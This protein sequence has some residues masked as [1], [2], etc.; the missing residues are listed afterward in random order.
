MSQAYIL[1]DYAGDTLAP[2]TIELL[3]AARVLGSVT[4]VVVG[5]PGSHLRFVEDLKA[6]GADT[7]IGAEVADYSRRTII[8]EVDAL[9]MLAAGNPGP[10][11][12][13]AGIEGNEIAGRLAARLASGVLCDVVAINSDRSATMSIFG[14]SIEVNAVVGGT[15]P[16]YTLRQGA[17]DSRQEI[18]AGAG[19]V[20]SFALPSHGAK[21]CTITSFSPVEAGERPDLSQAKVVICAGRGIDSAENFHE[22]AEPLADLFEGAVGATRDVVDL[23]WYPGQYQVGQTGVTV[24]PDLYIGLGISGAIQHTSGM[25]TS[26]TVIVINNDEDAPFFHIADLGI[27]G[28]LH[29]VVPLVIEKIKA[30]RS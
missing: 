15:S 1:V 8:P 24:S 2:S 29:E 20:S 11:V 26:R 14:D 27:V 10:I 7:I 25:Q 23:D 13:S 3:H 28:D 12:V 9:S 5:E 4:A 6:H 19:A 17:V 16:I 22:L 21:D 18:S 30:R